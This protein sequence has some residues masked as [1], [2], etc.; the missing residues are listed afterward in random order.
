[1]SLSSELLRY[2]RQSSIALQI[3]YLKAFKNVFCITN[4]IFLSLH[5]QLLISLLSACWLNIV[6]IKMT[7]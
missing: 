5:L 3:I 1:M 4:Y 2:A 7:W 6:S